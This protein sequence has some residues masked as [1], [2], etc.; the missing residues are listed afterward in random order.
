MPAKNVN[1][2][3]SLLDKR[4]VYEAFA[5]QLAPTEVPKSQEEVRHESAAR[6]LYPAPIDPAQSHCRVADVPILLCRW[7]G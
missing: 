5:S 4:G 6:T 3:A 2:N 1:G 7:P